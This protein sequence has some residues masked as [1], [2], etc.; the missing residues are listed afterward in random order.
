[1]GPQDSNEKIAAITNGLAFLMAGLLIVI[2]H[3]F[4]V[5]SA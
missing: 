1:M 4:N 3:I 2:I 5:G